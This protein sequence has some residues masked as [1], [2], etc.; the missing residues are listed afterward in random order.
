MKVK[1]VKKTVYVSEFDG[2]EFEDE[3]A[4]RR[5]EVTAALIIIIERFCASIP[6]SEVFVRELASRVKVLCEE[7]KSAE[8]RAYMCPSESDI[9][10]IV[11]PVVLC[12]MCY[13]KRCREI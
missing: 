1:E 2:Q 12:E 13:F 9:N 6:H 4:C 10:K 11:A 3:E 7:C 8:G 5:N